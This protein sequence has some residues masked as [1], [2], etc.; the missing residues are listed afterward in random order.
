M[1]SEKPPPPA[2]PPSGGTSVRSADA[3]QAARFLLRR[4]RSLA[5]GLLL[6][7]TALFV[8][9]HLLDGALFAVRLLRAGSEAGIVGGMADWFAVTALFRRPLGLPIPHTALVANNKD[10]FGRTLGGFLERHF[11]VPEILLAKLRRARLAGRFA[12]W[13]ATPQAASLIADQVVAALPQL[14]R[15]LEDRDLQDFAA[16]TLGEQLREADVA[17]ILGRG[18][19]ILTASGEADILFERAV[20]TAGRWLRE[21]RGK[22]DE[23]VRKRSR[24]WIP[25][26]IDQRIAAAIMGGVSDLL[27]GLRQPDSEVRGRFRDA[28]TKLGDELVNSKAHRDR[29]NAAKNRL[30]DHPDVQAWTSSVWHQISDVIVADVGDENSKTRAALEKGIATVGR[31]LAADAAMQA[32]IEG[33]LEQAA[34]RLISWRDEIG[35][36][37]AEV[38][39]SWDAETLSHRLEL[40]IGSDL[41]YIR[42]NGTLVGACVGCALFLITWM[43]E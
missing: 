6:A 21:N 17:P 35:A 22:L 30:L 33:L 2:A 16:R 10:R 11:L 12:A 5:T 42:M 3:E 7:M 14:V 29:L 20:E 15:S 8:L 1:T 39:A 25:K 24:W 37:I 23:M 18:V 38:I 31:T 9:S 36:F 19:R 13:L 27:E 41:Q 4:N 26:A 40:V 32:R 43:W 28:L 34:L